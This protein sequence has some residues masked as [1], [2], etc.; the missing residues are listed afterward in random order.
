MLS[1][2]QILN[3]RKMVLDKETSKNGK[4]AGPKEKNYTLCQSKKIKEAKMIPR[5]T[6]RPKR[7]AAA[8][9][10]I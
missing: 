7:L 10:N 2:D 8:V 1:E 3:L 5:E 6:E 4:E 9:A